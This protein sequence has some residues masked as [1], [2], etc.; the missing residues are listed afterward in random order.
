MPGNNMLK[1]YV[2]LLSELV[3]GLIKKSN[4]PIVVS[5]IIVSNQ[6]NE[7]YAV[8]RNGDTYTVKSRNTYLP[9]EKVEVMLP[10]GK[11]S[12]AFIVY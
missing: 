8:S 1:E 2:S 12:R 3:D 11:W 9:G 7:S 5:C 10:E 4:I 6:G